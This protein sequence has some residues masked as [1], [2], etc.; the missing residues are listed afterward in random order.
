MSSWCFPLYLIFNPLT[1]NQI[2]L[3][4]PLRTLED[5]QYFFISVL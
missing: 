4:M 1:D 2:D 5:I 3:G